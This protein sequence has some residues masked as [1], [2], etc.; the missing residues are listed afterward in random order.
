M[1]GEVA[2]LAEL[3]VTPRINLVNMTAQLDNPTNN[4]L[5]TLNENNRLKFN[6]RNVGV[7]VQG[8][9]KPTQTSNYD[10]ALKCGTGSDRINIDMKVER[11]PEKKVRV[12]LVELVPNFVDTGCDVVFDVGVVGIVKTLFLKYVELPV[13]VYL[14]KTYL[15]GRSGSDMQTL[16]NNMLESVMVPLQ[17]NM[18]GLTVDYDVLNDII[19]NKDGTL[20]L[21]LK[22]ILY[23]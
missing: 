3:K 7:A 10:F 13:F 15:A 4:M 9:F 2:S 5:M 6:L 21:S 8:N 20:K 1:D 23:Q 19:L 16:I 11:T 17:T 14:G 22:T 18:Y 12:Q